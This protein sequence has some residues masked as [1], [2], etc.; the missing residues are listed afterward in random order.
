L[1]EVD[2]ELHSDGECQKRADALLEYLGSP[3]E[4][5]TINTT[6]L[7]YGNNWLLPGD[8][9]HV[10]LPNEDINADYRILSVEF[11][12]RSREQTLEMTLELGKE[13]PKIVNLL[14]NLCSEMNS[15]ARYK[16]G[17]TGAVISGG[18]G[19]GGSGGIEQH[20]NEWHDPDMAL[21]SDFNTHT[22][23]QDAHH[24]KIHGNESHSPTFSP[25]GHM[26]PCSDLTDHNKAT[27]DSLNINADTLDGSHASA[28]AQASH[29]HVEADITNLDHNAQK[30]KG[31]AVDDSGIGDGK[32]LGYNASQD[33]IVYMTVQGGGGGAHADTHESGGSDQ[34]D[35]W[36]RP[37]HI[38]PRSDSSAIVYF[39]T[40][41]IAGDTPLDHRFAPTNNERGFI[42][43][44]S[45]RW[46]KI[47][48]KDLDM[49]GS[50]AVSQLVVSPNPIYAYGDIIMNTS[51]KNIYPST[52]DTCK[53]GTS[54]NYFDEMHA[55]NFITH[56]MKPIPNALSK[57]KS[58]NVND[59]KTFPPEVLSQIDLTTCRE[60]L[61]T[62]KKQ[63]I[64][65]QK[66]IEA[67]K[68]GEDYD[69]ARLEASIKPEDV[70]P[71][72]AEL[73]SALEKATGVSLV[74]TISLLIEAVKFI[75]AK[76]EALGIS[77]D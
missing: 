12:A 18:G 49:T 21:Q 47:Y 55:D 64:L 60:E 14:S 10:T 48:T 40:Q 1:V 52:N 73:Q 44:P 69:I 77:F 17:P 33:K 6:V 58:I 65:M 71:T 50:L 45:A 5:L 36:I 7:D 32:V 39:R 24:P 35:G 34:I 38:G 70:E 13:P 42:G 19:G 37:S 53:V 2:E 20:G 4:H 3:A 25:V 8:K 41:N 76:L 16:A 74:Q 75:I 54:T 29:T 46:S 31:K 15:L 23:N 9:I 68:K 27:H 57:L 63:N 66:I 28:F 11:Q 61:R 22:A 26:H 56:S 67:I 72:D 59:K 43:T 62:R 51:T 30:I